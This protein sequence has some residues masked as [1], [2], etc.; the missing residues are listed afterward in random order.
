MAKSEEQAP[1]EAQEQTQDPEL[2]Y[3]TVDEILGFDDL[4]T[5]DVTIKAWGGKKI[6]IRPLTMAEAREFA[7]KVQK[8]RDQTPFYK[9]ALAASVVRPELTADQ[10]EAIWTHKS[11]DAVTEIIQALRKLN[12]LLTDEEKEV[13]AKA[14][15]DAFRE[16][17]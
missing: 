12:G 8:D 11:A 4:D 10:V 13:Q 14:D 2:Q 7:K 15:E 5:V 17:Q 3:F 9:A 1:E 16:G 6:Q